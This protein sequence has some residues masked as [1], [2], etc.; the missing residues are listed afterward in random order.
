MAATYGIVNLIS[1][2]GFAA[3]WRHQA[4]RY[5][6]FNESMHV[7]DLMSGMNELC[8][9]VSRLAPRTLRWTAIDISPEM[10]RRG[11]RDWPFSIQ[12]YVGDV[13]TWNFAPGSADV[14]LSS[15]GLKTLDPEQQNTLAQAVARSLRPGGLFSFVEISVP[16]AKFL[17]T[18]YMF[19][20]NYVIPLV[21]KVFLG[22][23]ENYR[24]LGVYT[25]A[26]RDCRHF[27]ACLRQEGL[28]VNEVSYFW[29]C[30]TAVRGNKP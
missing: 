3:R 19:Y 18:P 2:F 22:N 11:R 9:A 30:A 1:S 7:F 24:M 8:H 28:H 16:P 5:L 4:T 25:K 12:S 13:L 17:R 15:F 23:P 14:V 26:F 27:A 6:R 29:G 21:G 20:L 10:V